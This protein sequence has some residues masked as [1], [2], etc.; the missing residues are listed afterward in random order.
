M[1]KNQRIIARENE[2]RLAAV[3]SAAATAV[4]KIA[5]LE[6]VFIPAEG[7]TAYSKIYYDAEAGDMVA[8][9]VV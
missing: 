9:P 3:E 2:A 4:P 5:A 1:A 8:I 6:E 7:K